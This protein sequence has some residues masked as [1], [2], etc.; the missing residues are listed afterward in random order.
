MLRKT[1]PTLILASVVAAAGVAH[2]DETICTS[3]IGAETLVNIFVPDGAMCTL[4]GT[5]ALGNIVVGTG[6]TLQATRISVVGNVLA[7]GAS[8]VAVGGLSS[9]AGSVQVVQGGAFAL[10]RSRINGDVLADSNNGPV[11]IFRNAIGGNLQAFQNT[12]GTLIARNTI[13]QALQCKENV[14]APTGGGNR[15]TIKQDQCATL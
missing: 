3:E 7:E 15:A 12:G 11:Q 5:R 2:A 4:T 14:P 9:I 8:S 6:S 13:K 10:G 1:I